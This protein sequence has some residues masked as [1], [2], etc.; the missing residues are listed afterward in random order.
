MLRKHILALVISSIFFLA[1]SKV[2]LELYRSHQTRGDLTAYAQGMWNTVNGHF[3][4]STYNYSVHNYYDK[5]YREIHGGNS[6]IFGIHFNPII[7]LFTPLY[8]LFPNPETLLFLQAFLVAGGGFLMF[9]LAKR[10]LK[11]D[12]LAFLI[13]VSYLIY[14][15]T[16]SAVLNQF[17]AYTLAL[18]FA[19]V[20]LLASTYKH[21]LA[22]YL[23]LGLFLMVQENTSLVAF[24]FGLY[25]ILNQTTRV[26]GLWTSVLS[27]TYFF[28]VIEWVIPSLSPY[29]FYL[30]S[31]IYGS[32]LGGNIK[33]IAVTSLLHPNRLLE[34]VIEPSNL[35]YIG[36]LLIGLAP[37]VLLSPLLLLV[38]FS[39]LVQNILSS[40]DGLKTQLMHYESGAVA[41][42]FYGLILGIG[43]FL[44]RTKIGKMKFAVPLVLIVVLIATGI[45]YKRFTSPRF[46]PSVLQ[47]NMYR[48][49][50]QE[51][52]SFIAVI[53][54]NTSVSTQDYLSAQLSD[55]VGLYQFPVYMD[56]VDYVLIAK[57]EN[58][59][60]LTN[61][62]QQGYIANLKNNQNLLTKQES[63][64]FILFER[65]SD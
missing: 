35:R 40:S 36:N 52:D 43:Y 19:P 46:N 16:V 62:E 54:S 28:T 31:G 30:F 27:L 37:F 3:M 10:I 12:T 13:Q 45:S 33:E 32:H 55:R 34:T 63:E 59:W 56:Q 22:Y 49:Q 42:L 8:A 48:E 38:A 29:G 9:L 14:F 11:Q 53:P 39:S 7:L 64:S 5:Q 24:F 15:A 2:S 4:A 26:R 23:G 21:N 51:M 57:K 1:Y 61:E 50:N 44:Q 60:P 6:N 47:V 18:F 58:V 20:L 25:L 17:H 41:F 65:V